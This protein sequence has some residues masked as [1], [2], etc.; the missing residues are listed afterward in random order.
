MIVLSLR[1][2]MT[3]IAIRWRRLTQTWVRSVGYVHTQSHPHYQF[4]AL[5][6]HDYRDVAPGTIIRA[7]RCYHDRVL[8]ANSS[9]LTGL[10]RRT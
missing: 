6:T 2:W 4:P 3:S 8:L 10:R 9:A 1:C 7:R 5:T